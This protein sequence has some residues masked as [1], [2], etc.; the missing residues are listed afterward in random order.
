MEKIDRETIDEIKEKTSIIK[1]AKDYFTLTRENGYLGIKDENNNKELSTIKIDPESNTYQ[2]FPDR[3]TR[4]VIQFVRDTKI[5]GI[6]S[7][8]DAIVF[9]DKRIKENTITKEL[10]EEVKSH[11]S[12][13]DLAN[14]YFSITKEHGFL[15]IK[16]VDGSSDFSSLRLYPDT[17]SYYRFSGKGMNKRD[18]ISFVIDT[19]IEGITS[20]KEAVI[21]LKKR[22]DPNF[23]IDIKK[24]TVKKWNELTTAEK[25]TRMAN[26]NNQLNEKL[27]IDDNN[28]CIIAYLKQT[29]GI[30]TKIIYDEIDRGRIAQVITKNGSKALGC[31]GKDF[32]FPSLKTAVSVRGVKKDST[33]KGDLEG[34]NYDVGWI[35][36]NVERKYDEEK[37]RYVNIRHANYH[38]KAKIYCFEGYIDYLSFKTIQKQ[39]GNPMTNDICIVTGSASKTRCIRNFLEG[40]RNLFTDANITLCFD[41]DEAGFKAIDKVSKELIDLDM[42][43][44]I[45]TAISYDKDWND[46]L[47]NYPSETNDLAYTISKNVDNIA[48]LSSDKKTICCLYEDKND[49]TSAIMFDYKNKDAKIYD[50]CKEGLN[51]AF[52]DLEKIS[53]NSGISVS[54]N[55]DYAEAIREEPRRYPYLIKK[56]NIDISKNENIADRIKDAKEKASNQEKNVK[57]ISKNEIQR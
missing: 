25:G 38:D 26:T 42:N 11:V 24:T 45:D 47:L 28:R 5:E 52:D 57:C 14:E 6:E 17:N 44:K 36:S 50:G 18:V 32:N 55:S 12:I 40:N 19:Q 27:Q 41:R 22:I 46:Q 43:L 48:T 21:F 34:C 29:R 16:D 7:F 1:L 54:L 10:I 31:I 30:D 49:P 9:L 15:G 2:R 51:I 23:N 39:H 3:R 35:I 56:G 53:S 33:F 13:I 37:D 4:D 20:F 8:Q